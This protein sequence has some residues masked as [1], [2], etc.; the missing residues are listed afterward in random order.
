MGDTVK[1]INLHTIAVPLEEE[2]EEGIESLFKKIMAG[3]FPN[4]GRDL[5]IQVLLNFLANRSYQNFNLKPSSSRY[6]IIKLS[7]IK[8]GKRILK[9]AE[10]F[11]IHLYE[12]T[13]KGYQPVP[14]QKPC[15]Q[16][17]SG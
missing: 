2:K 15:S 11:R 9:I 14:Q 8:N 7:K 6:I 1:K 3:N 4:L 12:R 13:P 17:E 5:H 16:E 10:N